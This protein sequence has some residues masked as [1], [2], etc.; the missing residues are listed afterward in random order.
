M[1]IKVKD[2]EAAKLALAAVER[3]K[4][5]LVRKAAAAENRFAGITLTGKRVIFLVDMSGSMEMVDENTLDPDKWPIVCETVARIMRSLPDLREYQVIIFSDRF[6]YA[7]GNDG[8]WLTYDAETSPKKV[9]DGLKAIKPKGGTSMYTAFEEVFRF[10]EAGLDTVYF[11]SDGLPNIGAGLPA[12]AAKLTETQKGE[13]L[14]KHI[15]AKLKSSWNRPI[16]GQARVRIN[17]I[18]FFFESPDLGAFLWALAREHDGSFV[19]M[20]RP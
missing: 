3:D 5:A 1:T 16:P 17:C 11:F 6:R 9:A 14:A 19:G 20:S 12:D 2:L 15:R 13:I 10:R 7:F 4:S 18:G 8:R